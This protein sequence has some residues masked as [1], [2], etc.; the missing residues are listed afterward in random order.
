LFSRVPGIGGAAELM[1]Y[2]GRYLELLSVG[3][4]WSYWLVVCSLA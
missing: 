1:I 3:L 2:P 4:A